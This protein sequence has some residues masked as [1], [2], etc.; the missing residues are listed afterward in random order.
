LL[1]AWVEQDSP[2]GHAHASQHSLKK[3]NLNPEEDPSKTS[4][5]RKR[6]TKNR[7]VHF[8]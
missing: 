6:T 2:I 4:I 8:G 1:P 3:T 5:R 7:H